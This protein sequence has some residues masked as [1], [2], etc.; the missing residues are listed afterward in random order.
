MIKKLFYMGLIALGVTMAVP[1]LRAELTEA[2]RP[3]VDDVKARFVP[4]RLRSMADQLDARLRRAEGLPGVFEGWLRRDFTGSEL[5]PWENP[6]Y[7]E[8]GR[9]EYFVGSM[10]PD[11][12]R[13]T[14]DDIT[15]PPRPLSGEGPRER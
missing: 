5:D 11:G 8:A 13:G 12:E 14:E 9:R 4:R 3:Y 1:S 2:V 15:E 6:Y 7:L 10:G